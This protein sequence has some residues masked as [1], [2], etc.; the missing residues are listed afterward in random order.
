[1]PEDSAGQ[2]D[3]NERAMD[4]LRAKWG[5]EE[6]CASGHGGHPKAKDC[7]RRTMKYRRTIG[8]LSASDGF[9]LSSLK[10]RS[11]SS[12]RRHSLP[13]CR[14]SRK[15]IGPM[16]APMISTI[17]RE[18]KTMIKLVGY[19][20]QRVNIQTAHV[21]LIQQMNRIGL[22]ING[23]WCVLPQDV[24]ISIEEQNPLFSG[25]R[26]VLLPHRTEH[27]AEP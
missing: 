8:A 2:D 11:Y 26:L 24:S 14:H 13:A 23:I 18:T 20:V 17:R 10:H 16:I 21:Q 25:Q 19:D 4:K 5:R 12:F 1:M 6:G 7:F 3:S 22:K 27:L 9:D 15:I